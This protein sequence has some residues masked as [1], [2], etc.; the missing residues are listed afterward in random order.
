MADI[1]QLVLN[2]L[3]VGGIYALGA[4]GLTLVYGILRLVN[5]AHGD[6]LT[7]GAYLAWLV[8]AGT[9]G[10]TPW[11]LGAALVLLLLAVAAW[12]LTYADRLRGPD[13]TV[14]FAGIAA[15]GG[16]TL[17]ARFTGGTST[18]ILAGLVLSAALVGILGVALDR[19]L[20]TRM[21]D[22]NANLLTLMIV[23]IG[24]AFVLRSLLQVVFGGEIRVFFGE[25]LGQA[26]AAKAWLAY[27]GLGDVRLTVVNLWTF[28][29][30]LL[31]GVTTA[32]VIKATRVGKAM[33]AL[34]DNEDLAR[35]AGID[36]ERVIT[37]VWLVGGALAGL[38]GTLLA[39]ETSLHGNLGWRALLP[40]FAAVILGGVGSVPGAM[41]GG[42]VIGLSQE[43][44]VPLLS[45]VGL[46]TGYK[47]AVGFAILIVTLIVRP[48]GIMGVEQA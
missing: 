48:R 7:V 19:V 24:L 13:R 39:M 36:T 20:W 14:L 11:H 43:L 32:W 35:V 42:L 16:V 45:A 1:P 18:A 12:D 27:V 33:R 3:I 34:S 26:T 47:V 46:S 10:V 30:V 41:L 40:L 29:T 15:V 17:A 28:G 21:R 22:R 44:S 37:Y 5:F 23:S 38:A 31:A 8:T 4:V 6:Y 9:F 25:A 2:G